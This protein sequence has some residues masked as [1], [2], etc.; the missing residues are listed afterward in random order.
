MMFVIAR[1]LVR[2]KVGV[3]AVLALGVFFLMPSNDEALVEDN[4]PW[5]NDAPAQVAQAEESGFLGGAID[6]AIDGAVEYLDEA[7]LNP[8]EMAEDSAGNWDG[9]ADAFENANNR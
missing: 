3:V 6:S 5:G 4:S 1:A 8:V 2:H 7:G 9:A